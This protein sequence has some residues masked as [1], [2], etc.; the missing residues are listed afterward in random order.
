MMTKTELAGSLGV[1]AD[2]L[3]ADPELFIQLDVQ[4]LVFAAE[5]QALVDKALA[6]VRAN[7]LMQGRRDGASRA[8]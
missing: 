3:G 2:R 8:G 7:A 6:M 5:S 4:Q 1:Y